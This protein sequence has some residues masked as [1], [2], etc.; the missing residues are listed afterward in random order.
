MAQ[1]T[2]VNGVRGRH[3]GSPPEEGE[4]AAAHLA[5]SA[6]RRGRRKRREEC[7]P[8]VRGGA[9]YCYQKDGG[10]MNSTL[11]VYYV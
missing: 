4:G 6:G 7:Q 3:G 8:I 5:L 1:L 11:N 10:R 2:G 9:P